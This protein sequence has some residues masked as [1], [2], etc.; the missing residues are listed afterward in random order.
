MIKEGKMSRTHGMRN[1]YKILVC[2]P[3]RNR[4]LGRPRRRGKGYVILAS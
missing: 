1:G 2:K 3:E 4:Q